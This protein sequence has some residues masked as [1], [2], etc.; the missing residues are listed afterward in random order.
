[1]KNKFNNNNENMKK[2]NNDE[3]SE[4]EK[5]EQNNL[6]IDEDEE[7]HDI[8]EISDEIYADN[9]FLSSNPLPCITIYISKLKLFLTYTI[10]MYNNLYIK[11]EIIFNIYN[12]W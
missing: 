4:L 3:K 11:N 5:N 8:N 12:K 7:D 1:M 2:T 9:V 6:Q 10:N